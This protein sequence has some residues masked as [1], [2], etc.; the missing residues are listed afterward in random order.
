MKYT[1]GGLKKLREALRAWKKKEGYLQND[2][3]KL[4]QEIAAFQR[5]PMRS[6]RIANVH[7]T[8]E[9]TR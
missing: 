7:S 5:L 9:V 4:K 1:K 3:T 6:I 2:R 8:N